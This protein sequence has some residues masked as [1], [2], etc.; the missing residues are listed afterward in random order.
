MVR[1]EVT[2]NALPGDRYGLA[3]ASSR[4]LGDEVWEAHL[5]WGAAK[6]AALTGDQPTETGAGRDDT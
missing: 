1:D 2:V 4:E 6:A 5:R 3:P